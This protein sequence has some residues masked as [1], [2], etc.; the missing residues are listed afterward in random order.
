M[1]GSGRA[2]GGRKGCPESE[3]QGAGGWPSLVAAAG[4]GEAAGVGT[5]NR[6]RPGLGAQPHKAE[7]T[8]RGRT[9]HRGRLS[10]RCAAARHGPAAASVRVSAV[11]R[12]RHERVSERRREYRGSREHG[13]LPLLWAATASFY[14]AYGPYLQ[15]LATIQVYMLYQYT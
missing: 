6:A 7:R 1:T 11:P 14:W 15:H 10:C 3:L 4:L 5:L 2:V 9:E 12:F 13:F 8:R